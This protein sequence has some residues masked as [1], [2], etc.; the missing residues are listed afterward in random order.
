MRIY[1]VFRGE[2]G[3]IST[4]LPEVAKWIGSKCSA[5]ALRISFHR[6]GIDLIRY[7]E[8]TILRSDNPGRIKGRGSR[9]FG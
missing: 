6:S 1:A 5:N 8:A 9:I 4:S 7:D 2:A 3:L